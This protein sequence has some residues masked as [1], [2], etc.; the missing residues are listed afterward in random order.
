MFPI[1]DDVPS[2]H[3]PVMTVLLIGAN[4]AAFLFAATLPRDQVRELFYLMGIVPARFAHPTWAARVGFPLHDYW[5]FLTSMFLHGGW[6]HLIGNMWTLWIFGDNVEDRMGPFRFLG[7]Y[8]LC[9]IA[10]GITHL[11]T[12]P[13]S[14]VPTVGA[15][16]AIAGVMGAYF[17]L[18]PRARILM[19]FPLFVFPLFFE[20][21]AFL[22]L[23]YWFVAQVLS[24]SLALA[25][26]TEVGGVAW[27]AHG[28]GFLAGAVL[29]GVFLRPRR[30]ASPP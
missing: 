5:P 20:I 1:R 8:L 15:S 27:W 24:G 6:L 3:A 19:L 11:L 30:G 21:P 28:G 25:G 18:Y 29:F 17:I 13:S 26:P 2:R 22:F 16:G 23:A 4:T 14:T 12:N 10:A 7:F 9:G